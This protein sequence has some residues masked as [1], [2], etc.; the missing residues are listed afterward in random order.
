[1]GMRHDVLERTQRILERED[2]QLDH[3]L[4]ELT[5]SRT[6]L[7]REQ[8]EI[9]QVRE[10][11]ESAR[12]EHQG[13][14]EKLRDRR[15]VLFGKMRDDLD[16]IFGEAHEQVAGVIRELQ[17]SGTAQ[18][19][20]QARERLLALEERTRDL[21]QAAGVVPT[22]RSEP[23]AVDWQR[24]EVGDLVEVTGA[25]RGR[26][27][28]LPDRRGRVAVRISGV[29]LLVAR[30]RIRALAGETIAAA[31]P[32]VTV[33][34]AASEDPIGSTALAGDAGRCDLRGLRVD[35]AEDRLLE[36]LDRA[37]RADRETLT[38]VH[39]VGSGAL[40]DA[41]RRFLSTSPYVADYAAGAQSQGGDGVTIAT[42]G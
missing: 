19:A 10:E 3:V 35:E 9:K 4:T 8:R 12:A 40:R 37:T 30:E 34:P 27:D 22:S 11:A 14:L 21:E 33:I 23:E 32:R 31:A 5:A 20:A 7:E 24:M 13:R 6:A 28:A 41:V 25:G 1:M 36:A 2:R 16:R 29:R 18:H 26:L 15:D 17:R 42:L 38:V 39:G